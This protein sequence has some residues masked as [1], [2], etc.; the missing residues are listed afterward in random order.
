MRMWWWSGSQ[1]EV[2]VEQKDSV[3]DSSPVVAPLVPPSPPIISPPS[4]T[5][6]SSS[7]L[8]SSPSSPLLPPSPD[9]KSKER[10]LL[11]T[12]AN[13]A[14]LPSL[15]PY[16]PFSPL[17]SS[18][19]N[20]SSQNCSPYA[21]A[22]LFP[23]VSPCP[24]PPPSSPSPISSPSSV[25][26]PSPS[27]LRKR[28]L[29]PSVENSQNVKRSPVLITEGFVQE[30]KEIEDKGKEKEDEGEEKE[31]EKEKESTSVHN[32]THNR[33]KG[34]RKRQMARYEEGGNMGAE[35][36]NDK[37]AIDREVAKHLFSTHRPF[38][39]PR[40][41]QSEGEKGAGCYA[42]VVKLGIDPNPTKSAYSVSIKEEEVHIPPPL[43]F[44]LLP[45]PFPPSYP[46]QTLF[47]FF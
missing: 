5:I 32:N 23:E 28:P 20:N 1:E 15:P 19:S 47:F 18:T 14:P 40:C 24:S 13:Q 45:S 31:N 26:P 7:P 38:I 29:K 46:Q 10:S 41:G 27:G 35:G 8:T 44:S 3:Q 36:Q 9:T 33:S 43:P 11:F 39:G 37:A 12:R 16:S 34:S 6:V 2:K 4:S 22:V 17:T 21:S 30:I 25:L 42:D